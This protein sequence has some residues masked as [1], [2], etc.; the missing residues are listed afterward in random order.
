MRL[1]AAKALEF[2]GAAQALAECPRI[3]AAVMLKHGNPDFGQTNPSAGFGQANPAV[4]LGERTQWEDFGRTNPTE[5]P[6]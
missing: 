3:T 2:A 6:H 4:A 5:V 1:A